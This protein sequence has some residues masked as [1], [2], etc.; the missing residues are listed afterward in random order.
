MGVKGE[1]RFGERG[2]RNVWE[3]GVF[4]VLFISM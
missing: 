2:S 4:S 3:V 1:K